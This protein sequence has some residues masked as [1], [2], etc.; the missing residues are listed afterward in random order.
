MTKKTTAAEN[1]TTTNQ[2]VIDLLRD[3]K[4]IEKANVKDLLTLDEVCLIYDIDK[5]RL[6][7][8]I[9]RHE[10]SVRKD[11]DGRLYVSKRDLQS[12]YIK[13]E[14]LSIEEVS[15]LKFD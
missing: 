3:I 1:T 8:L 4:A 14:W 6:K 9:K 12:S 10:I 15:Q 2:Q 11:V 7:T 5:A 13:P